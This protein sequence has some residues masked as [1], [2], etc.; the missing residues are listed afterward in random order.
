[1]LGISLP[2]WPNFSNAEVTKIAEV[3]ASGKVNYW[4]GTEGKQFEEEFASYTGAKHAVA[5]SNGTAALE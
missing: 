2:P 1:M 4:T 3:L 5:L